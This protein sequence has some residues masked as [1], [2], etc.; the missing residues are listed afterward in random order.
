ADRAAPAG[1]A[2]DVGGEYMGAGGRIAE[3]IIGD[4]A[5]APDVEQHVVEGVADLAGEQAERAD[6][7]LVGGCR[8]EQADVAAPQVRPVALAFDAEHPC[9]RLPAITDLAAGN[10]A[11]RVVAT[12]VCEEDASGSDVVPALAAATA[13]VH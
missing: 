11:G 3:A 12:F 10:T 2:D 13:H 1:V 4:G 8:H 9:A 6:L 5:A 7:G